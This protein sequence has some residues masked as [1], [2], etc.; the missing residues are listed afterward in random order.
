MQKSE[1]L[2]KAACVCGHVIS[3]QSALAL[4]HAMGAHDAYA[5][6]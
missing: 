1:G 6:A 4:A 5:H 2:I 3:A